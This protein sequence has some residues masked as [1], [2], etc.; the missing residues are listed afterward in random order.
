MLKDLVQLATL[1]AEQAH[2]RFVALHGAIAGKQGFEASWQQMLHVLE[3]SEVKLGG[4]ED[5]N[6]ASPNSASTGAR[7]EAATH[8]STAQLDG[9][10]HG[11]GGHEKL[12]GN[13][14]HGA[15]YSSSSSSTG[16]DQDKPL[17]GLDGQEMVIDASQ[18]G[19]SSSS[20]SSTGTE[21]DKSQPSPVGQERLDGGSANGASLVGASLSGA[22]MNGAGSRKSMEAEL[23]KALLSLWLYFDQTCLDTAQHVRCLYISDLCHICIAANMR[24]LPGGRASTQQ[25]CS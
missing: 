5:L 8:S 24:V 1:R 20:S 16:C 14:L 23:T 7:S 3:D 17:P 21:P 25:P 4:R 18:N 19:T 11:A 13:S 10:S 2:Q 9:I 12:N 22:N 6:S 15:G